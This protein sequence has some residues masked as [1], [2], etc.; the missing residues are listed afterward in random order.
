MGKNELAYAKQSVLFVKD[1][2]VFQ[3][4]IRSCKKLIS[5]SIKPDVGGIVKKRA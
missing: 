3:S 5:S 4:V 1:W 2:D